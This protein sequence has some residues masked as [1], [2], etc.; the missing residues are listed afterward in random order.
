MADYTLLQLLAQDLPS[1]VIALLIPAIFLY[2]SL[3][4]FTSRWTVLCWFLSAVTLAMF[5]MCGNEL[6]R[7]VECAGLRAL[8]RFAGKYSYFYPD[9]CFLRDL[10]FPA[11]TDNVAS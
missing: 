10:T 1:T 3:Y 8:G 5:C 9:T 7:R 6:G 11:H 2:A 4:A